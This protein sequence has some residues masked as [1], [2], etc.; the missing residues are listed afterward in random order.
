MGIKGLEDAL[1]VRTTGRRDRL[2]QHY[3]GAIVD[4]GDASVGVSWVQ[5][6]VAHPKDARVRIQV[7][8]SF[9]AIAR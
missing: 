5:E 9:S 8:S 6:L 2:Y 1:R 4:D 3:F 7:V